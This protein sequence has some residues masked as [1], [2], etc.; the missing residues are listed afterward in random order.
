VLMSKPLGEITGES[1]R[2][3]NPGVIGTA[4]RYKAE[5]LLEVDLICPVHSSEPVGPA[6]F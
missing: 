5:L 6:L 4:T 2:S 3:G 1:G